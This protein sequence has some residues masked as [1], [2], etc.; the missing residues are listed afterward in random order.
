MTVPNVPNRYPYDGNDSATSFAF[1]FKVFALEDGS[2]TLAVT[3][4]DSDGAESTLVEGVDY[5]VSGV[6]DDAGGSITYPLSGSPLATGQKLF[7]TPALPLEQQTDLTNQGGAYKETTEEALDYLLMVDKGQQEQ[8]DR[9]VKYSIGATATATE[10][11]AIAADQILGT[12]ADGTQI[13][14][15][16]VSSSEFTSV[17]TRAE[18]AQSA[19]QTLVDSQTGN[20]PSVLD[21][22]AVADADTLI[23]PV[24][25]WTD[26]TNAFVTALAAQG[27]IYIPAGRYYLQPN[28]FKIFSG[29]TVIGAGRGQTILLFEREQLDLDTVAKTSWPDITDVGV[30]IAGENAFFGGVTIGLA[31]TGLLWLGEGN[32][33]MRNAV[34]SV[35]CV[36]CTQGATQDGGDDTNYPTYWNYTSDLYL[37]ACPEVFLRSY[38]S[39]SG[40]SPNDNT[41]LNLQIYS[42]GQAMSGTNPVGMD[43]D[44]ARYGTTFINTEFDLDSSATALVRFG[45]NT[46]GIYFWGVKS[47]LLGGGAGFWDD[48]SDGGTYPYS[49]KITDYPANLAGAPVYD[50]N[51]HRRIEVITGSYQLTGKPADR[52]HL[53]GR[54]RFQDF[55]AERF[56]TD[57]EN[58]NISADTVLSYTTRSTRLNNTAGSEVTVTLP[59]PAD[60]EPSVDT[61]TATSATS[62]TLVDSGAGWTAGRWNGYSVTITGGTGVGQTRIVLSNSTTTLALTKAWAVTPDATSTYKIFTDGN[63]GGEWNLIKTSN[64]QNTIIVTCPKNGELGRL[65]SDNRTLYLHSNGAEWMLIGGNVF[66]HDQATWA[67]ASG[68]YALNPFIK[69]HRVY[70]NTSPSTIQLPAAGAA[71]QGL[72]INIHVDTGSQDFT[73]QS[74][75]GGNP[76]MGAGSGKIQAATFFCDGTNWRVAGS[77]PVS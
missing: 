47:E 61:G 10:L 12:N 7:L 24:G 25:E 4:K 22:G 39:G 70:A 64:D 31:G 60:Y 67:E 16:G 30:Q 14:T 23:A 33:C 63:A 66:R 46:G 20:M 1:N 2:T 72:E 53:V 11:G 29:K 5:S 9:A 68:T 27:R 13:Q 56:F 41:F 28:A 50:P 8:I 62:T 73:V 45:D 59:Y 65:V 77:Y 57:T 74:V 38:A 15:I 75:Y 36:R 58:L 17:A 35:E 18:A 26:N 76:T 48:S 51:G 3:L 34:Q 52:H 32:A 44:G 19:I 49:I 54:A 6:G 69:Y 40:D 37:H 71:Y 42:H 43:I 55:V 21:Y